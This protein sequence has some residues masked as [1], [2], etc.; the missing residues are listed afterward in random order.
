M[1]FALLTSLNDM[2]SEDKNNQ[3]F[4][5]LIESGLER[6]STDHKF[7]V[8]A[9][10]RVLEDH[11]ITRAA[12]LLRTR[13]FSEPS[14][15]LDPQ[16]IQAISFYF[17]LLNL[18]EEHGSGR[19]SRE[20]E[21]ELGGDVEPGRWGK[22]L[23]QLRDSGFSEQEVRQK[24]RQVRVEPV[25]TKHPTEAKRW[26]VLGL[27]R[28][29]VRL[30][31]K[32]DAVETTFES[33]FC[34]R[35]LH[36]V[37]ERLWL[38][39]E[40]FSRK[41]E[42][43][44]ELENL[45]YYLK[46]IFPVVFNTL[47]DRLRHAWEQVWPNA[48]A[49]KDEELP[50]LVFGSWV[51]GDRDGHPKVTAE[52]TRSTLQ[53]LN[54]GAEEIVRSR[55]LELGQ[56]LA[57]SRA[58]L[59]A[60]SSLLTQLKNWGIPD[61]AGEPW[62]TFVL[63]VA[64]R[65]GEGIIP[66]RDNLRLLISSLEDAGAQRTVD[67]YARPVLRLINS[68]GLHLARLDIRQNSA[69]Y[70][71]AL[72]QMMQAAGV[73]GGETFSD[74]SVGQKMEFL[75]A[76]LSHPRPLTHASMKLPPEAE[77]V[78]ATF[79]E[80]MH[81]LDIRG[82][83]G[84]GCL[85]V[86]MTRSV[87]DLLVVYVLGKEVGL[88]KFTDGGMQCS[89]PVVPLF[90][91]YD[92]LGAAP[93]IMDDFLSHPCTRASLQQKD[94]HSSQVIM[95][96]YSDSNKDTG[97]IAS[98]WALQ[99]AQKRLL[100]VGEKHDISLTF[101][102]GR[103]GTVGRGAGPTHRFLEALPTDSLKGGLRITEQGEVIG[104]KFNTATTASSNLETLLAGSLG[105]R[106]LS[107]SKKEPESLSGVMDYLAESSRLAYREL[108]ETDGFVEFYRQATPIDAIERSRIGSRPSRRTGQSSL[109]DL[110]AIPWV[111][112]WNQSRFYLPGWFGVGA[113]LELLK[114]NQPDW[115]A[116]LPSLVEK[117][118]FLRYVFYNAESSLA[119]SDPQ[120]MSAY[121]ELVEDGDLRALMLDKI[122][123]E[124]TLAEEHFNRL[125]QGT[126]QERRPRFWQT[127]QA[128][129]D[130]L[131]LLHSQQIQLLRE[132]RAEGGDQPERVER[133]LLVVNAI[134]SGLRTTG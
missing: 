78:R 24:L 101:F 12:D 127:L 20:R 113:G 33:T 73:E 72:G 4:G 100:E 1:P 46:Q 77:E 14:A 62:K 59:E 29:I 66:L 70:D 18:V 99:R 131:R 51:G 37:L 134:A 13:N 133:M 43:E 6:V 19:S 106:L 28:E 102:H 92:D 123:N 84:L 96:G 42:V 69:A 129:E 63:G 40:I 10:S 105:A 48:K 27:H 60:P 3:L 108:L 98:Q 95:L 31:R 50:T 2:N 88:T 90:E 53:T 57:F 80:L 32:R 7:L 128:R 39:G 103:G 126:L 65:L 74:W 119:S 122:M 81:H 93:E 17:Q 89:L 52:V 21:K 132:F 104:Q 110:R 11:G 38:T 64:D 45:S 91:T 25:F 15:L 125:F 112:S 114:T 61:D 58:G 56:K 55:L 111:F 94:P 41:P 76:E 23:K 71:L 117:S 67:L 97:I 16:S 121:A 75:N 116:E 124:R 30:L 85:V 22:Y 107:S 118:S 35:N 79:S 120:W 109:Q 36:A 87:A 86:S 54:K 5:R 82:P 115:F 130:A 34:D 44:N 8:N 83:E 47:D 9:F 68:F 26:A 49:L